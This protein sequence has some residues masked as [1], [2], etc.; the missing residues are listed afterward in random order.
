MDSAPLD[1]QT[2]SNNTASKRKLEEPEHDGEPSLLG[3]FID[4]QHEPFDWRRSKIV[5]TKEENGIMRI[6]VQVEQPSTSGLSCACVSD[7]IELSNQRLLSKWLHNDATRIRFNPKKVRSEDTKR[8]TRHLKDPTE[9][10][11]L[12]QVLQQRIDCPVERIARQSWSIGTEVQ[13]LR[14]RSGGCV[15]TNATI[16]ECIPQSTGNSSTHTALREV[17]VYYSSSSSDTNCTDVDT[18][19]RVPLN[20]VRLR[21]TPPHMKHQCAPGDRF[22]QLPLLLH[23]SYN[24]VEAAVEN[25]TRL[26][27]P[28]SNLMCSLICFQALNNPY[29]HVTCENLFCE[30]CIKRHSPGLD[31][32]CPACRQTLRGT[33]FPAPRQFRQFLQ[34]APIQCRRCTANILPPATPEDHCK[35][36]CEMQCRNIDCQVK[37]RGMQALERHEQDECAKRIVPCSHA[38]SFRCP[39][40]GKSSQLKAHMLCCPMN[41]LVKLQ[42]ALHALHQEIRQAHKTVNTVL[43]RAVRNRTFVK[44]D[45]YVDY[46]FPSNAI[47]SQRCRWFPAQVRSIR[48]DVVQLEMVF[49]QNH[50]VTAVPLK[51]NALAPLHTHTHGDAALQMQIYEGKHKGITECA[52][53]NQRTDCFGATIP[54]NDPNKPLV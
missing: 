44:V 48:A 12:N 1:D 19:K 47:A 8:F 52:C 33:T 16:V 42:S 26:Y 49:D 10:D 54:V 34:H 15:W 50:V 21:L 18:S 28:E 13:I 37:C 32:K 45:A 43:P 5:E 35:T 29:Q 4:W 36:D 22:S 7:W 23:H 6:K 46:R 3:S 41:A 25:T 40:T 30:A 39:W 24:S 38:A 2:A 27:D 20:S 17:R 14:S 53:K 51:S 31:G 11:Y 9:L